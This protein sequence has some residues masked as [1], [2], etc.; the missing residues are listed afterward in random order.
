MII[1]EQHKMKTICSYGVFRLDKQLFF[2]IEA[3]AEFIT[4]IKVNNNSEYVIPVVYVA[5][6]DELI[7]KGAV[8][9]GIASKVAIIKNKEVE[10]SEGYYFL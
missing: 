8:F 6:Y 9:C 2:V 1:N 10:V 5:R 4:Y 7:E 3:K